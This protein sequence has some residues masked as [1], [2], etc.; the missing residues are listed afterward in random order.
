MCQT[1]D[2]TVPLGSAEFWHFPQCLGIPIAL[3]SVTSM[4]FWDVLEGL[5]GNVHIPRA[6]Q[7]HHPSGTWLLVQPEKGSSGWGPSPTT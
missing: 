5:V 6:G 1:Q 4:L 2:V 3:L 7:N